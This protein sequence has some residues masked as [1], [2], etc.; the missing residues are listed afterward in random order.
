MPVPSICFMT[1]FLK[2]LDLVGAISDLMSILEKL[3]DF[4]NWLPALA[5]I[6]P[7]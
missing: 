1:K 5:T 7:M 4:A 3:V 2:L 6:F